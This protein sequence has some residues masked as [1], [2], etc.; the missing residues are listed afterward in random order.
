MHDEALKAHLASLSAPR[1]R[2]KQMRK[3]KERSMSEEVEEVARMHAIGGITAI[4]G[5]GVV[6]T[7]FARTA[8]SVRLRDNSLMS[9]DARV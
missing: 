4:I 5:M 6:G 8:M 1:G 9:L 7:V 2:N 3:R